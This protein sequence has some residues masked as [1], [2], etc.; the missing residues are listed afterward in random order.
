[1]ALILHFILSSPYNVILF[2]VADAEAQYLAFYGEGTDP[3][4]MDDVKCGGTEE[5]LLQCRGVFTHNCVHMEDAGVSCLGMPCQ[6]TL[7]YHNH[8]L[9]I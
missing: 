6:C 9:T 4:I 7:R 8:V 3:I 1:M 5:S 2:L